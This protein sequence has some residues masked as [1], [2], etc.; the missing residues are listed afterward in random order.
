MNESKRMKILPLFILSLI[1]SHLS[2]GV[3]VITE[4]MSV[5][6]GSGAT[7]GD[8]FEITNTGSN[9]I[10]LNNYVWNDS[11]DLRSD[12]TLFPSLTINSGESIVIVDENNGNMPDWSSSWDLSGNTNIYGKETFIP[13]GP[14]GDDFSGLGS[15]GDSIYI[16]DSSEQLIISLSFGEATEG[17]SFQWDTNGNYLGLSTLG[18]NGASS[19]GNDVASPGIAV[20]EPSSYALVS[21]FLILFVALIKRKRSSY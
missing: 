19:N 6:A 12:A 8:W 3:L 16:W 5:S 2:Y 20:P 17:F 14:T 7:N 11:T 15:S 18:V 1:I 10:N 21:G 9:S 4:V 13:F